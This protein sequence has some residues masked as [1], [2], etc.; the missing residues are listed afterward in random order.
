MHMLFAGAEWIG[1]ALAA[2]MHPLAYYIML[3]SQGIM[4]AL[5]PHA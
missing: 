4:R 1:K 5:N 2:Y 3:Q